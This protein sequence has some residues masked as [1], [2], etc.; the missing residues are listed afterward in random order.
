MFWKKKLVKRPRI[1]SSKLGSTER[2]KAGTNPPPTK[3]APGWR[4]LLSVSLQPMWHHAVWLTGVRSPWV[5][6]AVWGQWT[7][8]A[9]AATTAA[10]DA[11]TGAVHLC[12]QITSWQPDFSTFKGLVSSVTSPQLV[13][14]LVTLSVR[15]VAPARLAV[16]TL[17]P[18]K[19]LA[20]SSSPWWPVIMCRV[21]PSPLNL[22]KCW[23]FSHKVTS[24]L[25][26]E[27]ISK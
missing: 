10:N 11:I 8:S 20:T 17:A 21:K 18:V 27:W 25:W 14:Q 19:R 9:A 1:P 26:E 5:A 16:F 22:T 13:Y 7:G 6:G 23:M 15:H 2:G 24:I 12:R 3:Y 4:R